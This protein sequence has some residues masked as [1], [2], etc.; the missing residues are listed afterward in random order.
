[1][2]KEE[3]LQECF[4]SIKGA[5]TIV[6]PKGLPEWEPVQCILDDAEDLSGTAVLSKFTIGFK[7]SFLN[8]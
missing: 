6:Y 2:L 4:N 3:A 1:M 5:I 8:G 7:G